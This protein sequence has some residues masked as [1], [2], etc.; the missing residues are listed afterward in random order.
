MRVKYY[1]VDQVAADFTNIRED[2]NFIFNAVL[3]EIASTELFFK[4]HRSSA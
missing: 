4:N 3:P 2:C 1:L